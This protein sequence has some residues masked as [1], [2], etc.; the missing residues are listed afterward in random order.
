MKP[1]AHRLA[2]FS[3][4]AS[5]L[6]CSAPKESAKVECRRAAII[7]GSER[8]EYVALAASQEGAIA[9]LTITGA[10][11]PEALCTSVVVAPR[12]ALTARHCVSAAES[13]LSLHFELEAGARV[14][15]VAT[16]HHP[17]LDLALLTWTDEDE[18]I[19]AVRA[20]SVDLEYSAEE[21]DL[22]QI[23]GYGVTE[24]GELGVLR[25]ATERI[26][27]SSEHSFRV[28][29]DHR[30]GACFG[31]SGGPALSRESDGSVRLVGVLSQGASGCVGTDEY[32]RLNG[33]RDWLAERGVVPGPADE[34]ADCAFVG[35]AGRCFGRSVLSCNGDSPRID[36]CE[37]GTRCGYDAA[38][39]TF[40]C[41]SPPD[42]SCEGVS[43]LGSCEG[44]DRLSCED[45]VIV[46][47]PCGA[48][49]ATCRASVRDGRA[50]CTE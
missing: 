45:G 20:I 40:A 2:W 24:N 12:T 22:V 47:S 35:R 42:D 44:D 11:V 30:A 3:L 8:A 32:T 10:D 1:R 25:Y 14:V 5:I 46:S 19:D 17:S 38:A 31:D 33:V 15:P 28:S 48:C 36:R 9:R 6:A 18:A 26:V 7:G 43:D 34:L 23:G 29:A 21:G 16:E 41:V 37:D 13:T 27:E 4:V 50:I 39:G 49:G